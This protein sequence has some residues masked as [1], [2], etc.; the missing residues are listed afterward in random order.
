MVSLPIEKVRALVSGRHKSGKNAKAARKVTEV[1]EYSPGL[2][3]YTDG[4]C[5]PNPGIGGWSFVVYR[6]GEEIH[7]ECGGDLNATNNTMEMTAA[8]MALRWFAG[9]GIVEPVKILSDSQY[10]VKGCNEWRIGWKRKG[11]KRGPDKPLANSDLWKSLDEALT[12]VPVRLYWV[13]GHIGV[14]GNERADELAEVGRQSVIEYPEQNPITQQLTY[15][16]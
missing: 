2:V 4:A 13:K 10:T 8:L 15:S 1:P 11:W 3:I 12:A 5:E 16:V 14:K 7:H 9:R 6:D